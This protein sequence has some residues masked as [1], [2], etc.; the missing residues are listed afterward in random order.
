MKSL[1]SN[2]A[3][4]QNSN[5]EG[6]RLLN[7]SLKLSCKFLTFAA[8][9]LFALPFRAQ[10]SQYALAFSGQANR[11]AANFLGS[12]SV[13]TGNAYVFTSS[14]GTINQNPIGIAH[15]CYWLDRAATGAADHCEGGTPYDLKGTVSCGTATC[16]GPW[17][18]T[19]VT[20]GW[21]TMSE[22]VTLTT[23]ATEADTVSFR[24]YNGSQLSVNAAFDD[25][26]AVTGT[27]LLQSFSTAS[28][29]PVT[30]ASMPLATGAAT[31]KLVL[32]PDTI[33]TVVILRADG[34][35]LASFPFALLS[36]LK[37]DP[38]CLRSAA[39][40]LVFRL[41][42]QSIKQVVPQVTFCF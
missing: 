7:R 5:T 17:N 15:V 8:L 38:A 30:I 16:G 10:A 19:A 14:A 34:S 39:L 29:S 21:H 6:N 13:L 4:I 1:M 18:T 22:L 35:Q 28:S 40:N 9:F 25:G 32:Q 11:G 2:C 3:Q 36:V 12:T 23:G 26:S 20:D 37:V 33:Y 42:D 27:L 41:A 31:Y 24:T